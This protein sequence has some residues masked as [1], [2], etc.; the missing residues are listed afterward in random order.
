[1][2]KETHSGVR[3]S[4]KEGGDQRGRASKHWP[5]ESVAGEGMAGG[6]GIGGS[7]T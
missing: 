5:T 7:N 2:A 6:G 1:M 3:D 4:L